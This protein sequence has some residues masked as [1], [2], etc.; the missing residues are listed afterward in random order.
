M[1]K[2][3]RKGLPVQWILQKEKMGNICQTVGYQGKQTG[4]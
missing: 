4:C 3:K 1:H 2:L